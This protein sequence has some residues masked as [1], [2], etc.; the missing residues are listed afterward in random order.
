MSSFDIFLLLCILIVS[1]YTYTK[2]NIKII[3]TFSRNINTNNNGTIKRLKRVELKT[4]QNRNLINYLN[5][6]LGF[7]KTKN[8]KSLYERIVVLEEELSEDDEGGSDNYEYE[9]PEA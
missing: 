5:R 2:R 6:V 9:L 7:K 1:A 4:D 3:E 8:K